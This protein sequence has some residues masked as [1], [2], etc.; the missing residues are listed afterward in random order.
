[1]VG[2]IELSRAGQLINNA[3]FQPFQVFF[4]VAVLYFAVC[5]PLS[6]LSRHIEGVLNVGRSH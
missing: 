6:R 4:V 3:T 2:F 5:F 1:V